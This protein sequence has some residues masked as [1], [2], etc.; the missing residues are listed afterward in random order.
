MKKAPVLL[1]L[2][3]G[4]VLPAYAA[5][6]SPDTDQDISV[7]AHVDLKSAKFA[8][9]YY[10]KLLTKYDKATAD[11]IFQAKQ[12]DLYLAFLKTLSETE[13]RIAL[14]EWVHRESQLITGSRRTFVSSVEEERRAKAK[15]ARLRDQERKDRESDFGLSPKELDSE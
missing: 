9:K 3:L 6:K 2:C 11:Y 13:R 10:N 5:E 1:I 7:M 4:F 14:E 8:S 12:H 15:K